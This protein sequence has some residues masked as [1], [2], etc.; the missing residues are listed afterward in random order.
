MFWLAIYNNIALLHVIRTLTLV[1]I[2]RCAKD[3]AMTHIKLEVFYGV[4]I[5]LLEI[6]WLIYGN[7][8]I[9]D[10]KIQDCNDEIE[11]KSIDV[12]INT[13][14]LRATAL[15]LIVYGYLLFVGVVF[16]ILFY[17]GAYM[18]YQSYAKEDKEALEKQEQHY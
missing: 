2:W 5:F 18:G 8:F 16:T 14:T 11:A 7:T 3:P 13:N 9:Y 12:D 6:V 10:D 17:I 1:C 15:T 4:W